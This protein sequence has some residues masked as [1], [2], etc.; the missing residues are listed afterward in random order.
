MACE[1]EEDCKNK[2]AE[3][4]AA[5]TV[6]DVKME[7]KESEKR[8]LETATSTE[9][10]EE[11]QAKKVKTESTTPVKDE[12]KESADAQ[13]SEKKTTETKVE[14]DRPATIR[15]QIEYY[16][17]NEN[18]KTDK[19]FQTIIKQS[20]G[21]F[22]G[23]EHFLNCRKISALKCVSAEILK[24]CEDSEVLTVDEKQGICRKGNPEL[25]ELVK[26]E[27]FKKQNKSSDSALVLHM[28]SHSNTTPLLW[29]GL[30]IGEKPDEVGSHPAIKTGFIAA[31]KKQYPIGP[32]PEIVWTYK[33]GYFE[34]HPT[35]INIIVKRNQVKNVE[36]LDGLVFTMQ[37]KNPEGEEIKMDLTLKV[38]EN[39][40]RK[41]MWDLA[42][43]YLR[44]NKDWQKEVKHVAQKK[45][46]LVIPGWHLKYDS[47][48][49]LKNKIKEVL[50][51]HSMEE[52]IPRESKDYEFL[53]AL[54]KQHPD[55]EAKLEGLKELMVNAWE[56]DERS[57]CLFI[58]KQDG[59][60]D[61]VSLN[62]CCLAIMAATQK[63]HEEE[64]KKEELKMEEKKAGAKVKD[65]VKKEKDPNV[66][67]KQEVA[68]LKEEEK[69]EVET[70]AEV[71]EDAAPVKEEKKGVE[72]KAEVKEEAAP[73]KEE[74][75]KE[76]EPKSEVKE[77][78]APVKE[79][80]KKEVE[81]KAE[82][83]EE[84]APVKEEEKKEEK[85]VPM[86]EDA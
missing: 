24:S 15:K 21:G 77:E 39:D 29:F 33:K 2:A 52:V 26:R 57:R 71:K 31:M 66:E 18:L 48:N 45:P 27:Q 51:S 70:N 55:R 67:V 7:D 56:T 16:M 14:V 62:K 3:T 9:V 64:I 74:E 73:V 1:P 46:K 65:E 44:T 41:K 59:T 79:E 17:S 53:M 13:A 12:P 32:K 10:T 8:P 76:V 82:V 86:E 36:A 69:K 22:V 84:A 75:K 4:G 60:K 5:E 50:M 40:V 25:P 78:A 35:M 49:H 23:V 68:S 80:E 81:P 37:H 30:D 58:V 11:P 85:A 42:P 61:P 43:T 54:L 47:M 34:D 83:K 63:A 6:K 19:F 72:P 28:T 20:E 38:L